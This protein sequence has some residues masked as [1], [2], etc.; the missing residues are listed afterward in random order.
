MPVATRRTDKLVQP[1]LR[2][3]RGLRLARRAIAA[4]IVLLAFMRPAIQRADEPQFP[5]V[6]AFSETWGPD[7]YLLS[8][9][10]FAGRVARLDASHVHLSLRNMETQRSWSLNGSYRLDTSLCSQPPPVRPVHTCLDVTTQ[11]PPLEPGAYEIAAGLDPGFAVTAS[12]APVHLMGFTRPGVVGVL[13]YLSDEHNFGAKLAVRPVGAGMLGTEVVDDRV[14]KDLM[15]TYGHGPVWF[16]GDVAFRTTSNFYPCEVRLLTVSPL[17]ITGIYRVKNYR[18]NVALGDDPSG[19]HFFTRTPLVVELNTDDDKLDYLPLNGSHR[20]G[21]RCFSERYLYVA[22]RWDF[23]RVFS[24]K[25][26]IAQFSPN[27]RRAQLISAH[28]AVPIMTR[29][30]V[31][32]ALGFP[33]RFGTVQE[34]NKLP[35]WEY[36]AGPSYNVRVTFNG[37]YAK[38]VIYRGTPP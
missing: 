32:F 29:E 33:S 15:R 14:A 16:Y 21:D 8:V 25:D 3:S 28:V 7:Q 23:E 9:L 18:V 4:L 27:D 6:V 37:D 20:I 35:V 10:D 11:L 2:R 30:M 36:G 1:H 19:A 31:A 34:L 24:L 17:E 13:F 22:D 5:P 38:Q 26:P 12:G